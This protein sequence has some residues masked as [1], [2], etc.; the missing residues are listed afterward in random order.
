MSALDQSGGAPLFGVLV[1]LIASGFS[2]LCIPPVI[3]GSIQLA[4]AVVRP[5][6]LP[7]ARTL[8]C[9]VAI[10]C[11]VWGLAR[12]AGLPIGISTPASEVIL[13]AYSF[14][15]GLMPAFTASAIG[16]IEA[17]ISLTKALRTND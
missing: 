5:R 7:A 11:T 8:S 4:L 1:D 2:G 16:A 9:C 15:Y 14:V 3:V 12:A 17:L 13:F 6:A 10:V